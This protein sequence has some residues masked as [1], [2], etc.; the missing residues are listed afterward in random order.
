MAKTKNYYL[1]AHKY[2]LED[3]EAKLEESSNAT[4]RK[5]ELAKV[6]APYDSGQPYQFVLMKR[7]TEHS[8][9]PA[10]SGTSR[11]EPTA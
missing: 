5:T 8:N 2:N 10:P 1:N 7:G 3:L 11:E 4:V 6:R 9:T